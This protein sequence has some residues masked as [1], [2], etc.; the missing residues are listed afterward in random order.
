MLAGD[1]SKNKTRGR[2]PTLLILSPTRELARQIARVCE[3]LGQGL[4]SICIYGGVPYDR[5]ESAMAR[6][7]DIVVGTPGRVIDHLNRV[8]LISFSCVLCVVCWL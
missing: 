6:G 1:L 8:P 2:G 3:Q 7:L 4:E 5:Q